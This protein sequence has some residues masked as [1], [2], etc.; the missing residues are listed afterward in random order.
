MVKS[1]KLF[2]SLIYYI[3][4]DGPVLKI[5]SD[6]FPAVV[7]ELLVHKN[8][9]VIWEN[10][11]TFKLIPAPVLHNILLTCGASHQLKKEYPRTGVSKGLNTISWGQGQPI[12]PVIARNFL[13]V[14]HEE[15]KSFADPDAATKA[16]SEDQTDDPQPDTG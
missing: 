3:R 2:D 4:Y 14:P 9:L 12:S 6:E 1:R 7:L 16:T 10:Q 8:G 5:G 11:G 13:L 15:R